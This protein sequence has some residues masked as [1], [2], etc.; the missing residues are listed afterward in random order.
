MLT[1]EESPCTGN[2]IPQFLFLR[3]I[4]ADELFRCII[5]FLP[6]PDDFNTGIGITGCLRYPHRDKTGRGAAGE[7]PSSGFIVPMRIKLPVNIGDPFAL[8]KIHAHRRSVQQ[9]VH[10][11]V[12]EKVDLIDIEDV[13]VRL[14]KDARLKLLLT[15]FECV[16]DVETSDNLVFSS[17]DRS[18]TTR[19]FANFV[20]GWELF[21]GIRGKGLSYL[22]DHTRRYSL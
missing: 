3:F 4:E 19:I 5:V 21:S 7:P 18:S 17:A 11:V 6:A 12:V 9:N 13:A 10:N 20:S 8:D 15:R 14:C 16:L 22:V 1:S 2:P